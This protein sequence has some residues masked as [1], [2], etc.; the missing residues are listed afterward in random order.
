MLTESMKAFIDV[1]IDSVQSS[2]QS[3]IRK[4]AMHTVLMDYVQADL[5]HVLNIYIR[6]ALLSD[7][8]K[9]T[10]KVTQNKAIKETAEEEATCNV[11]AIGQGVTY[12]SCQTSFE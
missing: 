2:V 1:S 8:L 4:S 11:A 7:S 9:K 10:L 12:S 3:I 5:T 6:N